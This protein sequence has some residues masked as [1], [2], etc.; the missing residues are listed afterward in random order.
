MHDCDLPLLCINKRTNWNISK[1]LIKASLLHST[2][3][4]TTQEFDLP[5]GTNTQD[6]INLYLLTE[7]PKL[8]PSIASLL[9]SV[10]HEYVD[11][12]HPHVLTNGD[13]IAIIP[14]VSGG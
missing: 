2:A 8:T 12:Q 9:L 13:E 14:P 5:H 3:S 4:D 6:F 11:R 10:N 7:F 1:G